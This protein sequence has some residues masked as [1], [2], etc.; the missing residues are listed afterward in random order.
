[1]D[2]RIVEG[3]STMKMSITGKELGINDCDFEASG[4]TAGD[5]VSQVVD[6][7]REVHDLDMPDVETILE[8]QS[9]DEFLSD[10]DPGIALVVE[11]LTSKLNIV[12]QDEDDVR[13]MPIPHKVTTSIQ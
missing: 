10:A 7:L 9:S 4:D 11:R 1:M 2:I 8:G 13:P 6:H 5:V 3:T 12:R